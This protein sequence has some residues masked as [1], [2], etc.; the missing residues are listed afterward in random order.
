MTKYIPIIPRQPSRGELKMQ[1]EQR[2]RYEK[3]QRKVRKPK[4]ILLKSTDQFGNSVE[5]MKRIR[6]EF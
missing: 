3:Q 4:E 1:E 6:Q 5:T 2:K